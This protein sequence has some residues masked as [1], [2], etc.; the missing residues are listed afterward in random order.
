MVMKEK[1]G[2]KAKA[3]VLGLGPCGLGV[4]RSLA[5][6][7]VPVIGISYRP[8]DAG[9]QSRHCLPMRVENPLSNG[10]EA[11]RSLQ[12]VG[13][14]LDEKGVLLPT[15]DPFVL[16]VSRFRKELG[17]HFLLNMPSPR[18][19]E[20]VVNKR[21][22]YEEALSSG[23]PIPQTHFP[24][25]LQEVM[26]IK[27]DLIYPAF[28]KPY[29]SHLWSERFGTK[30][31]KVE[32]RDQLVARFKEIMPTGLE[33]MVQSIIQGPNTNHFKFSS[34]IDSNGKSIAGFTSQKIRQYPTEFG[35][36][37]LMVS[38][39]NREVMELGMRFFE[40][41]GYT[42]MGSIEFKRD[43]ADGI[44]HIIE[45]NPR[46]WLQ[47]M[48]ATYSGLNFPMIQYLDMVDGQAYPCSEYHD[49]VRW[50]DAWL[51]Y[52]SFRSHRRDGA[53]SYADLMRTWTGVSCFSHFAM[54]DP[55]P[56]LS[57]LWTIS[58]D[59]LERA[60]NSGPLGGR[61]SRE[62]RKV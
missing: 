45:L 46:F 62:P 54:D 29:F 12:K 24:T 55:I 38:V 8:G 19:I 47:N 43:E 28:L 58:K 37:T 31:F 13:E 35:V 25:S 52:L 42:G 3:L 34:Y 18:V 1:E 5:R 48:Q 32:N 6:E 59:I 11:L 22:F 2:L 27:D 10:E 14:S 15:S 16:F 44:F 50:V 40:R 56:S 61:L 39:H 41:I 57:S 60:W 26:E 30:G 20:S 4:V 23:I 49:G 36:G 17:E 21:R 7:G 51:D 53:S 9:L 33:V